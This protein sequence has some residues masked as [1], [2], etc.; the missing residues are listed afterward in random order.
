MVE[1]QFF[2]FE[3]K[4]AYEIVAK[5][6]PLTWQAFMDYHFHAAHL[7]RLEMVVLQAITSGNTDEA[8]RQAAAFGWLERGEKGLKRNRERGEFEE[9]LKGLSLGVPWK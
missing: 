8:V 4:T 1:S 6:C 2:F 9:K 5:W 7:S 3:Q